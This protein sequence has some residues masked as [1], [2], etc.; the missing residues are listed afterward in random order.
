[1]SWQ[2]KTEADLLKGVQEIDKVP[3]L[4]KLCN[5]DFF[6][7]LGTA[8]YRIAGTFVYFLSDE[9]DWDRVSQLF[10]KSDYDDTS[11]GD[12]FAQIFGISLEEA[13]NRW[14]DYLRLKIARHNDGKFEAKS[15]L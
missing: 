8:L 3:P 12:T 2:E 4:R 9:W 6:F 11:I 1:M 15:L 5:N 13:D 14:R 7:G 10:L